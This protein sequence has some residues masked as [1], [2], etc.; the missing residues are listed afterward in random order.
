[1]A[2][3]SAS[4]PIRAVNTHAEAAGIDDGLTVVIVDVEELFAGFGSVSVAVT[5]AVLDTEPGVGEV[6]STRLIVALPPFASEPREHVTV[7]VL[8][9]DPCDGVAETNVVPAGS[10]SVTVT[11]LAAPGP[12]LATYLCSCCSHRRRT[13]AL[14]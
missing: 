13:V 5:V 2:P 14:H 3:S 8:L 7:V 10:T 4:I 1:M 6:V 11:L 12:P 9:H